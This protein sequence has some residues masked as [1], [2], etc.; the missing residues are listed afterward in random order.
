MVGDGLMLLGK[1]F[2]GNI[3]SHATSLFLMLLSKSFL[4]LLR[5]F[6]LMLLGKLFGGNILSHAT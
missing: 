6:F 4:I 5:K 2:S 1:L 3:L